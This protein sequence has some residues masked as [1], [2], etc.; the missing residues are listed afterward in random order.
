MTAIDISR[1]TLD[2]ARARV[3]SLS[4]TRCRHVWLIEMDAQSIAF[5]DGIFDIVLGTFVSCSVPDPVLGRAFDVLIPLVKRLVGPEINRR[6]VDNIRRAGWTVTAEE[7]LVS[8]V[9]KLIASER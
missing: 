9:V 6:T 5:P 2:R 7:N 4:R 8:D 1:A 3:A